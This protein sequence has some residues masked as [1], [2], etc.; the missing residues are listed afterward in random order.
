VPARRCPGA[1]CVAAGRLCGGA[2]RLCGGHLC[3]GAAGRI[4]G[5]A[6]AACAAVRRPLVRRGAGHLCGGA[7]A[8]CAAAFL[9]KGFL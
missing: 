7:Q 4:Y 8:A 1:A 6:Q 9:L 3:A 5:M 2:G